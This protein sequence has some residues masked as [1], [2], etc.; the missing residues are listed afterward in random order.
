ML[1]ILLGVYY[2]WLHTNKTEH[3]LRIPARTGHQSEMFPCRLSTVR[4]QPSGLCVIQSQLYFRIHQPMNSVTGVLRLTQRVVRTM[5]VGLVL[6][7]RFVGSNI[8][9]GRP[10]W[11][12]LSSPIP[13]PRPHLP[14]IQSIARLTDKRFILHPGSGLSRALFFWIMSVLSGVDKITVNDIHPPQSSFIE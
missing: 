4:P 1:E 10:E 5:L 3:L 2:Y 9:T 11:S 7:S 6:R 14:Q 12:K 8:F 13:P